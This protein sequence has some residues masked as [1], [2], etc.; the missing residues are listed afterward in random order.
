M[1]MKREL[2]YLLTFLK[3]ESSNKSITHM[4]S[5]KNNNFH[6]FFNI[7][8]NSPSSFA[9]L[10]S[11]VY[12]HIQSQAGNRKRNKM[13]NWTVLTDRWWKVTISLG[14]HMFIYLS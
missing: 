1:W 14:D 2:F 4:K 6:S 8:R 7:R 11:I 9:W 5:N 13:W 10:N 12:L 3:E